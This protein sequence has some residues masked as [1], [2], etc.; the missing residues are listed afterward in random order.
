MSSLARFK[1][2]SAW[3][4]LPSHQHL[5]FYVKKD[6]EDKY[7]GREPKRTER[8]LMHDMETRNRLIKWS[9]RYQD[10]VDSSMNNSFGALEKAILDR[11][12]ETSLKDLAVNGKDVI[13]EIV[14]AELDAWLKRTLDPILDDAARD[15]REIAQESIAASTARGGGDIEFDTNVV[16]AGIFESIAT[17]A[18]G[19]GAVVGGLMLGIGTS[20]WFWTT[21]SWPIL[22]GGLFVGGLLSFTGVYRGVKIRSRLDDRIVKYLLPKLKEA[23]IQGAPSADGDKRQPSV[24]EMVQGEIEKAA[25]EAIEVLC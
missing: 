9:S 14:D 18:A 23:L 15:F 5:I 1:N 12:A 25:S 22:L 21:I 8:T 20:F 6:I 3:P 24:L 17:I 10:R 13:R 4:A 19:I 11:I 2:K 7:E 16:G